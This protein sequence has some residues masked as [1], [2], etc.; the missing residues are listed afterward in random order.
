MKILKP[1]EI[2]PSTLISSSVPDTDY[3]AFSA[4]ASYTIGQRVQMDRR[5]YESLVANNVGHSPIA[6][7]GAQWWLDVGPTNRWAMF[8][9][10]VNTQTVVSVADG[11]GAS[12][13][14]TLSIGRVDSV[15]LM[16]LRGAEVVVELLDGNQLVVFTRAVKLAVRSVAGWY[17]YFTEPFRSKSS[18]FLQGLPPYAGALLRISVNGESEVRCGAV[19]AGLISHVGRTRYGGNVGINDFSRKVTNDFG[20]TT[21]IQRAWSKRGSFSVEIPQVDLE[22]VFDLLSSLRGRAYLLVGIEA[23]GYGPTVIY[24]FTKDFSIDLALSQMNYCT[25]SMEGLI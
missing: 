14:V 16:E 22:R 6:D 1:A 11:Q 24:G 7:D 21:L 18:V 19:L 17:G 5:V 20:V 9:A 8:D 12:I 13:T 25:L 15:A 4:S 23:D 2:T 3:P 10:R